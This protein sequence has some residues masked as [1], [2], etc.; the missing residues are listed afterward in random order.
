MQ[1]LS[2]NLI[3][4]FFRFATVGQLSILC[5][6]ICTVKFHFKSAIALGLGICISG[7]L[8]LTAPIPN[9]FYGYFR[10]FL[11]FLTELMP[12]FLWCLAYVSLQ[13]DFRPSKLPGLLKVL[14]VFVII[15]FIYFFGYLE[16]VGWFHQ[17]N[18]W[19]ALVLS[20]HIIFIAVKGLQDDLVNSR[21][22]MRI[23]LMISIS[24]YILFLVTLE[25]SDASL[26]DSSTFSLINALLFFFS[27]SVFS[28]A[29]IRNSQKESLVNN[30]IVTKNNVDAVKEIKVPAVFL[31][32][33]ETLN[34]LMTN[35]I[36]KEMNLTIAKLAGEL[37]LPEH[38]LRE[39]I[40]KHLGFRNFSDYLNS[41]RIPAA[42]QEFEDI[43]KIRK[44]IL[45]IALELGFGSIATF[46]RAF[47]AKTGQTPKEYRQKFQ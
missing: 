3:D 5:L 30:L 4:M 43:T 24:L 31:N 29:F 40:N 45:T 7:Y 2:L 38:Q 6:L 18:H 34:H 41:Y 28:W 12:Y 1:L 16:G 33:Y 46:N 32:S 36:Y 37:A 23:L 26:R 47:K 35:E 10:G 44:P 14:L 17:I 15:W 19:I 8:L 13:D 25:L 9:E 20:A 27:I 11:L 22:T 39:L 21:R 42:C